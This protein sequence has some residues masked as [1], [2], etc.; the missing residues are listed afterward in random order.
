MKIIIIKSIFCPNEIYLNINCNAVKNLIEL[1]NSIDETYIEF[2]LIFI[3]WIKKECYADK[4]KNITINHL[5]NIKKTTYELWNVNY[6]KYYMFNNLHKFINNDHNY[7]FYLDHDILFD[8]NDT[9]IFS[10]LTDL[11]KYKINGK[12]IGLIAPC[13]LEDNRH[14]ISIFDVNNKIN[15]NNNPL[16]YISNNEYGC[17]ACGCIFLSYECFKILCNFDTLSVYGL[18]DYNIIKK[19]CDNNFIAIIAQHISIIH[20]FDNNIEYINWK[21]NMIK[22]L[23]ENNNFDY[24]KSLEMSINFWD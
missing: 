11:F 22:L 16:Y 14:K 3:G 13:Q 23:I 7:V 20:P 2:D 6:G 5:N 19:V 8:L 4:I 15:I 18:D 17:I 1:L 10:K 21:K 9:K 24:Y 12:N